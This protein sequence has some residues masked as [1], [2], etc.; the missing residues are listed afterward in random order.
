MAKV[1]N[2]EQELEAASLY[3]ALKK[4]DSAALAMELSGLVV[5]IGFNAAVIESLIES[6]KKNSEL[7]R[8]N[9][10]ISARNNKVAKLNKLAGK[11]KLTAAER[12]EA[13]KLMKALEKSHAN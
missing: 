2:P 4:Y 12:L 11:K 9:K 1:F 5:G 8:K 6:V 13:G 7:V 10:A 3:N